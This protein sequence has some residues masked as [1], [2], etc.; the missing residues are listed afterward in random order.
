M[1]SVNEM[2]PGNIEEI[3]VRREKR[4]RAPRAMK[5]VQDS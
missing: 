1:D 4:G 5:E 2:S 3:I